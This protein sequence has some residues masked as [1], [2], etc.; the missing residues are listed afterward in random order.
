LL[1]QAVTQPADGSDDRLDGNFPSHTLYPDTMIAGAAEHRRRK[2]LNM[3][4]T[5]G[6]NRLVSPS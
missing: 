3:S 4:I 1:L 5:K 6:V 2:A